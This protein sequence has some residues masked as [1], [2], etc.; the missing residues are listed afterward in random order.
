MQITGED[1]MEHRGDREQTIT[2]NFPWVRGECAGATTFWSSLHLEAG[3]HLHR[4]VGGP[5]L[6]VLQVGVKNT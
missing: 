2:C 3:L 6:T 4:D 1:K 5:I